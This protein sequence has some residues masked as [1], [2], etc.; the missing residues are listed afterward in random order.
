MLKWVA[1]GVIL[2]GCGMALLAPIWPR[3]GAL[4]LLIP[5]ALMIYVVHGCGL[6]RVFR[7]RSLPA[8]II[9]GFTILY[10]MM[11][12]LIAPAIG[13][14]SGLAIGGLAFFAAHSLASIWPTLNG[15]AIDIAYWLGVPCAF[16]IGGMLAG[17]GLNVFRPDRNVDTLDAPWRAR[18]DMLG[19]VAAALICLAYIVLDGGNW[20]GAPPESDTART[21]LSTAKTT[22]AWVIGI[23]IAALIP[24]LALS[25]RDASR[26][27]VPPGMR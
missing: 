16:G 15:T 26:Q 6:P 4:G 21:T 27:V 19:G 3:A 7:R 1:I 9:F 10:V 8:R 14:V 12:T 2:D 20:F 11:A 5:Y 25:A 24:H 22:P 13:V 18:S 23:G 17:L